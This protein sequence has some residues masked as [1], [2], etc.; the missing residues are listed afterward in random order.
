[1]SKDKLKKDP[2][3]NDAD[4][5][6]KAPEQQVLSAESIAVNYVFEKGNARLAFNLLADNKQSTLDFI[7]CLDAAKARLLEVVA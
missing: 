3:A 4:V 7:E 2:V 1:M 6:E 5:A